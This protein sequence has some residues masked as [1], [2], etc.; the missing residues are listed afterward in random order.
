MEGRHGPAPELARPG[1][2]REDTI[3]GVGPG[4]NTITIKLAL[5]ALAPIAKT[6]EAFAKEMRLAAAIEWY[7]EGRVSQGRGAEIAGLNGA[8][9]LEALSRAN[10]SAS[11][12]I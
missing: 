12:I 7:R 4:E 10:R 9:F 1:E 8:E 2:E 5:E 11:Q 3:M 6:P